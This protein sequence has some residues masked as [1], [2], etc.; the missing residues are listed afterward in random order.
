MR[1]FQVSTSC[2]AITSLELLSEHIHDHGK[3]ILSSIIPRHDETLNCTYL[4]AYILSGWSLTEIE[5]VDWVFLTTIVLFL[6]SGSDHSCYMFI[7]FWASTD[8]L[9]KRYEKFKCNEY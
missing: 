1:P 6:M 4:T 9:C 5:T 7:Y 3:C 8:I 2:T